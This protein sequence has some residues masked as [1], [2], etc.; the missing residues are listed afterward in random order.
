MDLPDTRFEPSHVVMAAPRSLYLEIT[1][2]CNLKC[3]YC[4]YFSSPAEADLD[5]P[6]EEWLLFFEELNRCAVMNV[7]LS[8]GEPFCRPDLK[9]IIEGITANKMR[10]SILTN[11]TLISE[12]MAGFL[13]ST[14]RCDGIQ[15]SLDGSNPKIHD[16][17][18]GE[19]TFCKAKDAIQL[20]RS[21]QLPV[22]VR[23]TIHKK[24]FWDLGNI[25]RLLL[26]ELE[27]PH[28]ST[29]SVSVFGRCKTNEERLI[30][31]PQERSVA[32]MT[33]LQLQSKYGERITAEAGPLAEGKR[34]SQMENARSQ[35]CKSLPGGGC[36][37]GCGCIFS[38][39]AVRADGIM[40]PCSLLGHLE[41]GRVNEDD[42]RQVWLYHPEMKRLRERNDHSLKS[43]SFCRD[44][45]Y[46]SYC[47]GN[48]PAQAYMEF[49]KDDHP[50]AEGCLKR[51]LELGGRLPKAN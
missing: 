24:N 7:T 11:G 43:F 26:E 34:W 51:F 36:L 6:A 17:F 2:K 5:L 29:N 25:S 27:L 18:R 9:E 30:L 19:G 47:T 20:L 10:Y 37:T 23:V 14:K 32:M 33:L 41:L 48:C 49:G 12:E 46:V 38:R 35:G 28:F 21:H 1:R 42:L 22:D 45:S 13:S 15:I 31:S 39:M 40:V 44:C 4:L 3:D 50:S 8:G 16:S